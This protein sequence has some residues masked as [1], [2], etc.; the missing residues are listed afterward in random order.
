MAGR[1]RAFTGARAASAL[2]VGLFAW[3]LSVAA[4]AQPQPAPRSSGP[5]GPIDPS[6]IPQGWTCIGNCGTDN[7]DGVVPLSPTGNATYEWVSTSGGQVG[8]GQLPSGALGGETD[9]SMLSTPVFS[10]TAGTPL[11]FFFDYVTSDGA[12][13]ADY[14]WAELFES[15]GAPVALLFTARTEQTGSIIPGAAMPAPLATLTPSSVPI[16]GGGP[17]WAPLGGS[18]GACFDT[19]CGDT[20]WVEANYVIPTTGNYFLR[21]GVVNWIDQFFDSGLAV[22]GVT[23]GGA[24]ITLLSGPIEVEYGTDAAKT[25]WLALATATDQNGLPLDMK[26]AAQQM[27]FDHFNWLQIINTWGKV[28]DCTADAA[29]GG[30]SSLFTITGKVPTL[31]TVDPP[32]GGYAYELCPAGPGC[33]TSFP[34]QDFWSPY[35]DEYFAPVPGTLF[36]IGKPN[37]PEYLQEFWSGNTLAQM[38]ANNQPPATALGYAFSDS[39]TG[40]AKTFVDALVGVSGSCNVL[41]SSNCQWQILPGTTFTW[42]AGGG[43][44][45]PTVI[46]GGPG[47]SE[48]KLVNNAPVNPVDLTGPELAESVI[49]LQEFLDLAQLTPQKLAAMGGGIAN[50][51]GAL[52]PSQAAALAAAQA[53]A[54][55]GGTDAGATDAAADVTAPPPPS[56]ALTNVVAG[57]PKQIQI[58]VQDSNAGIASIQVTESNN[59]SV[60]VPAFASGTTDPLLVVATK[61]DQ[62]QG[63]QVALSITSV[64][65]QVTQCDPVVPGEPTDWIGRGAPAPRSDGCSAGGFGA[66]TSGPGL[67]G[68]LAA[69]A[70]LRGRRGKKPTS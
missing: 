23:I 34:V 13:F 38:G 14:A 64:D 32:L 47:D 57:P 25:T 54:A 31:P 2:L 17:A 22:D 4:D 53:A 33:E 62:S 67:F 39:P 12:G 50:F 45:S 49:S 15:T 5:V 21:V 37:A 40:S 30:C 70:F 51:S 28:Q 44:V 55:D 59:A 20:G 58:T 66:S 35:L 6:P 46:P 8:A 19:G 63:S 27:G 1:V 3:C 29:V 69:L 41:V 7:A 43:L 56:C 11:N 65:G 42:S 52:I 36:Y 9:G 24:P 60:N 10:A 16:N 48:T 26:D 18:S 68:A 61:T